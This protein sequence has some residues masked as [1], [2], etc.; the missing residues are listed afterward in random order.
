MHES[1]V[2]IEPV[3]RQYNGGNPLNYQFVD[4]EY[5]RKFFDEERIGNLASCFAILAIFISCLGLL[6]VAS[7]VAEMR[8]KEIS[9]RKLLGVSG[10]QRWSGEFVKLV[11]IACI[12][13]IPVAWSFLD[14]W[15]DKYEYPTIISWTVLAA[16]AA[17][18]IFLTL[19]TIIIQT[20][21]GS[22]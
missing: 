12:I 7:F 19:L 22:G 6:G 13:A 3:F 15:L 5:A 18:S 9:V 21:S 16:V 10:F 4:S 8:T 20:I 14:K 1:L 2:K 17:G 11:L